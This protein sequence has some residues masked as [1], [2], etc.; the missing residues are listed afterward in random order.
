MQR[1]YMQCNSNEDFSLFFINLNKYKI[2][3]KGE[4][5]FNHRLHQVQVHYLYYVIVNH[6]I[7]LL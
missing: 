4:N 3:P 7:I 2:E 5:H 6:L 1:N